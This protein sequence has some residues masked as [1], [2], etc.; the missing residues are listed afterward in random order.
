MPNLIDIFG[1]FTEDEGGFVV[2][3]FGKHKG[4][5]AN[6]HRHYLEWMQLQDFPE[7]TQEIV[8]EVLSEVR[9]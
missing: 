6:L 5:R 9:R 4:D 3:N 7:D 2:F 1:N 8:E